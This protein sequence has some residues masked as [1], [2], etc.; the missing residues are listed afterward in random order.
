MPLLCLAK[1][2]DIA[3]ATSA[4]AKTILQLKA[5]SNVVL[6]VRELEVSFDGISATDDTVLCE[7]L[8]QTTDGTPNTNTGA[9]V[10]KCNDSYSESVQST[11][12][13]ST[14]NWTS[15]PTASDIVWVERVHT[16]RARIVKFAPG[17]LVVKG[18]GRIAI[19]CTDTAG[20]VNRKATCSIRFDEGALYWVITHTLSINASIQCPFIW[21]KSPT[22]RRFKIYE[23][24]VSWNV[25]GTNASAGMGQADIVRYTDDASGGTSLTFMKPDGSYAESV[26]MTAQG[27][28]NSNGTFT[29]TTPAV[30]NKLRYLYLHGQNTLVW[31][32]PSDEEA[33][34]VESG[35]RAGLYLQNPTAATA[36]C[37]AYLLLKE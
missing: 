13:T 27:V 11:V 31:V 36:I 24:G 37:K 22:N 1:V 32:A 21:V 30:G 33:I 15:E 28:N 4:A 8:R 18:G 26:G 2:S 23:A 5:P 34:A 7:A 6:E 16:Q 19:R 17:E 35:G 12:A 29:T 20:T 9:T 14:G 3:L 25:S 10:V